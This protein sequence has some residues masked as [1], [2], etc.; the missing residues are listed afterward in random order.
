MPPFAVIAFLFA[1]GLHKPLLWFLFNISTICI[2]LT[3][4][5][6]WRNWFYLD[7][8]RT[9]NAERMAMEAGRELKVDLKLQVFGLLP[10]PWIEVKD[11]LP[12]QL[13]GNWENATKN[14]I[15]ARKGMPL[16]AEYFIPNVR[17]GIHIWDAIE[18]KSGDPLGFLSCKGRIHESE[19]LI[20]YPRTIDL[21]VNVFFPKRSLGYMTAGKGFNYDMEHPVGIRE[22]QLG[23]GLSRI[24]W[25]STA[26]VGRLQ[27]KEFE[28]LMNDSFYVI[29]DCSVSTWDDGYDLSFEEAVIAA[30][31][32]VKAMTMAHMPVTFYSNTKGHCRQ[33]FVD[34]TNYYK[35]LLQ[36]AFIKAE[37]DD[38]F[39]DFLCKTAFAQNRNTVIISSHRGIRFEKA[40]SQMSAGGSYITLILI[41]KNITTKRFDDTKKTNFYKRIIVHKADDLIRD[42]GKR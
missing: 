24:A 1:A 8:G 21:P 39:I 41:K 33:I 38:N 35:Y 36:M 22:Y 19:K 37:G 42:A 20:V 11:I 28:P 32:I 13:T 12:P 6:R 30:A 18:Y 16:Q 9:I 3:L 10:W 17:R 31:S 34:K 4:I 26:K 23:D 7:V 5:Y 40:L 25:K 29:M 14:F 15:W 2:F 27:S